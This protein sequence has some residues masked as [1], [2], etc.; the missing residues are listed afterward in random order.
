MR[1]LPII[2][3]Y[4]WLVAAAALPAAQAQQLSPPDWGRLNL[5]QKELP[6]PF[7][8]EPLFRWYQ[9]LVGGVERPGR[10]S[11]PT[12]DWLGSLWLTSVSESL[13][14]YSLSSAREQQTRERLKRSLFFSVR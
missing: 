13:L 8:S 3:V 14:S 5:L 7:L 12:N 4:G 11:T 1:T 10:P 6:N 2:A 9:V